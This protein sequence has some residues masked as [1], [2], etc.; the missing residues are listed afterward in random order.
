MIP[1]IYHNYNLQKALKSHKKQLKLKESPN[2]REKG[3]GLRTKPEIQKR[4]P[5]SALS[6]I[7]GMWVAGI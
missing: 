3:G 7:F 5:C 4:A 2:N 1:L 6:I